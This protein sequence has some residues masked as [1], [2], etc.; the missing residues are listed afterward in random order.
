M[1]P[2]HDTVDYTR[3]KNIIT[4]DLKRIDGGQA[5]LSNLA[6]QLQHGSADKTCSNFTPI[7]GQQSVLV[8]NCSQTQHCTCPVGDLTTKCGPLQLTNNHIQTQCIDDQLMLGL[9][10]TLDNFVISISN[11]NNT[12][13]DCGQL[14]EQFPTKAFVNFHFKGGFVNL[15]FSQLSPYRPTMYHTHVVGLDGQAGNII[16]YDGEDCSDLG[17]VLDYPGRSLV[18]NPVTSDEYPVGELGPKIG[19]VKGRNYV[20][21]Q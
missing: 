8:G 9:S 13:L 7:L 5:I 20:A 4:V 3:I 21:T 10:S 11:Q 19:G 16:V 15:R 18:A 6:W 12:I 1:Q 2:Q 14:S 17:N